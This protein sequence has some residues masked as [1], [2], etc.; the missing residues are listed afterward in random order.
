MSLNIYGMSHRFEEA[1][2]YE[3]NAEANRKAKE[4]IILS[5]LSQYRVRERAVSDKVGTVN[6][7]AIEPT[8]LTNKFS[9]EPDGV[10]VDATTLDTELDD[11]FK[12]RLSFLKID[13]KSAELKVLRRASK[14][15]APAPN[16]LI[17]FKRI[18]SLD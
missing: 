17:M 5:S 7:S 13:V 12:C 4:N 1:V 16:L 6:F 15:L 11:E 10:T 18:K 8:E 3:A 9:T 14:T 2:L